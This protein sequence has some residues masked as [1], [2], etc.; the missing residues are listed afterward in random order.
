MRES[1][2]NEE[3][4]CNSD[5]VASKVVEKD[6]VQKEIVEAVEG[7]ISGSEGRDNNLDQGS[8]NYSPLAISTLSPV[9]V[10]KRFI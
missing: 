8:E 1:G 2:S 5:R 7:R 4:L 9:L 6:K 10:K 3:I